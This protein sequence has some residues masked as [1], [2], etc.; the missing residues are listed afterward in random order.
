LPARLAHLLAS[1]VDAT[2]CV[3]GRFHDSA[4]LRFAPHRR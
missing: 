2:N 1:G 4:K 3:A